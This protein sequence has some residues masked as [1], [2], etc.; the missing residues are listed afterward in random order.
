M[1][2]IP[3]PSLQDSLDYII[4]NPHDCYA[5]PEIQNCI[6]SKLSEY[7]QKAIQDMHKTQV[8]IPHSIA[9]IL[10]HDPQLISYAVE[11]FYT[12]D[13]LSLNYCHEMKIFSPKKES[14][15][16]CS[17]RLSRSSFAKLVSQ[18]MIPLKSFQLPSPESVEYSLAELG[19]KIVGFFI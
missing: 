7:P 11:A 18:H 16:T 14:L 9:H 5:S 13:P 1:E 12:R 19:M 15:V 6:D 4:K 17:I 8:I 10:Y 2:T 3:H